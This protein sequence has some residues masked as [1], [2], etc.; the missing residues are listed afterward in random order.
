MLRGERD[1]AREAYVKVFAAHDALEQEVAWLRAAVVGKPLEAKPTRRKLPDE[2]ASLTWHVRVGRDKKKGISP[3]VQFGLYVDG[4]V[5]EVFIELDDKDKDKVGAAHDAAATA[6]SIALQWGSPLGELS[7]KW[8]GLHGGVHGEVWEV[9]EGQ[10]VLGYPEAY[11]HQA[12]MR[13]DPE[14][15]ACNSLLDAIARKLLVRYCGH[16]PF[17]IEGTHWEKVGDEGAWRWVA[18]KSA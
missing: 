9:A 2:R 14:V 4:T 11:S 3:H 13:R 16:Y 17:S 1:V 5:G 10:P 8:L 6:F 18:E 15:W 7:N 12:K